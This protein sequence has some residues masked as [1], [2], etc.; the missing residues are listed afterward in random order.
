MAAYLSKCLGMKNSAEGVGIHH[1]EG[2][3]KINSLRA[4]A[5]LLDETLKQ[6]ANFLVAHVLKGL[7]AVGSEE[8]QGANLAEDRP[9]RVVAG[10]DDAAVVS[11][12]DVVGNKEMGAIGKEFVVG[13]EDLLGKMGV[14]DDD[15]TLGA[16]AEA[17]DGADAASKMGE[18]V[19]R[20]AS[21]KQGQ[22][23]DEGP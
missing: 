9:P 10:E 18:D 14:A 1:N 6:V 22:V 21:A 13:V 2:F 5:R 8:L 23:T 17:N 19:M 11:I 7:K 15:G 3:T 12:E 20:A 16:E 4:I